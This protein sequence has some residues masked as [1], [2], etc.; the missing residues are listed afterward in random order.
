MVEREKKGQLTQFLRILEASER[1]NLTV[2]YADD[3]FPFDL[4]INWDAQW[5]WARDKKLARMKKQK[6]EITLN[7]QINRWK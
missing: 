3:I 2:I 1:E 4:R 6:Q 7:E 5:I